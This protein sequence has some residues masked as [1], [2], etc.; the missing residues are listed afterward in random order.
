[1]LAATLLSLPSFVSG[2][3]PLPAPEEAV[4]TV[5]AGSHADRDRKAK[6]TALTRPRPPQ[7]YRGHDARWWAARYHY[8]SRQLFHTRVRLRHRWHPTVTYAL[9]LASAVTGVSYWQLR[10]VSYCE[11]HHFPFASNG[12]Y[13]GIFQLGWSP[14]GLSPFDPIANALSAAMTVR[15][16]GSWRQWQCQPR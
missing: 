1:L 12:K 10:S 13:K 4:T 15:H 14:F 5:G 8:R 11:S 3:S 6:T 9:R 16:D 7:L 2:A